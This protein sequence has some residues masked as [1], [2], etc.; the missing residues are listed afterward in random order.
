MSGWTRPIQQ[1]SFKGVS[2]D[3]ISIEDSFNKAIAE[4]SYPFVNG[5]DLEDMGLEAQTVT[6]QAVCFGKG[7]YT[8]YKKLLAVLQERGADVLVHPVRGRMPNMLLVSA[9]LR[10]DAENVNYVTLDLTFTEAT[11]TQPIFVFESSLLNKIDR[12]LALYERFVNDMVAWW[13]EVMEVVAFAHNIKDRVSG[14]V[15]QWA[16]IYGCVEQLTSL[17]ELPASHATLPLGVNQAQFKAQSAQAL[18]LIHKVI[19]ESATQRQFDSPLGVKA[20][21]NE[22]LRDVRKVLAIPRLL[23]AGQQQRIHSAAQFFATQAG[24][25]NVLNVKLSL[26]DVANLNCALHLSACAVLAKTSATII[27]QQVERLTPTEVEY[28][29]QQTRAVMVETLTI[30]RAQLRDEQASA[31]VGAPNTGLYTSTH[32]LSERLRD[33]AGDLMQM[34]V[35]AIN[36]KPPLTVKEV[37]FDCTLVQ[38]AHDFY[39]D[40]RRADELLRLNPQ[41]RQ[42]TFVEQGML[43]NAYTR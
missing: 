42:P 3:V 10:H 34:A 17:F 33:M 28:M 31:S 39:G 32:Q 7:Y 15:N 14:I 20:E 8:Q 37:G 11:P 22:L 21:F 9:S 38:V 43:L 18:N 41:L 29:T 4:H 2:F 40:W 12:Y 1:A 30:L 23:V 24:K 6:L 16:G 26:K 27:E 35:A 36:Q 5:A 25:R 13:A 19:D